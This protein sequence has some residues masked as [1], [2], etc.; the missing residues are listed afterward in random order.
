MEKKF[1]QPVTCQRLSISTGPYVI[2]TSTVAL[3][4]PVYIRLSHCAHLLPQSISSHHGILGF[5]ADFRNS[6]ILHYLVSYLMAVRL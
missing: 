4:T 1:C 5:L 6:I 3:F 2:I